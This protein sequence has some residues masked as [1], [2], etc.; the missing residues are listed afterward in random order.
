MASPQQ[1]Q[2]PQ[3]PVFYPQQQFA[4]YIPQRQPVLMPQQRF[5]FPQQQPIVQNVQP[6]QQ[7]PQQPAPAVVYHQANLSSVSAVDNQNLLG[8]RNQQNQW[9]EPKQSDYDPIVPLILS[10]LLPGL[11]HVII[12]QT[13]K[14]RCISVFC[15]NIVVGNVLYDFKHLISLLLFHDSVHWHLPSSDFNR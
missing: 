13:N 6:A 11:G 15:F 5:S 7:Q 2:Q 14:V 12:G 1:P 10:L 8:T 9:I 4:T 3:Q